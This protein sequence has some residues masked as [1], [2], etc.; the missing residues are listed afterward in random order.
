MNFPS[1]K[2][3]LTDIY[4]FDKFIYLLALTT[5]L[6]NAQTLNVLGLCLKLG[7]QYEDLHFKMAKDQENY[8]EIERDIQEQLESDTLTKKIKE[9]LNLNKDFKG[10]IPDDKIVK[11]ERTVLLYSEMLL[12]SAL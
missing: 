7:K 1:V 11:L 3:Y 2:D 12:D 9:D 8:D 6:R 4:K 10:D 5:K